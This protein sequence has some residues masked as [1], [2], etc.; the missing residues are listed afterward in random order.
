M[1]TAWVANEA[2][3]KAPILVIKEYIWKLR[4]V[5]DIADLLR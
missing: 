2:T 5:V 1:A 4:R 3:T